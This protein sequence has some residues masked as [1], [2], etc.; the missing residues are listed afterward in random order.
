M[1]T[2]PPALIS[3][4]IP[5]FVGAYFKDDYSLPRWEIFVYT[6]C[7]GMNTMLFVMMTLLFL[8]VTEI[9]IKRRKKSVLHLLSMLEP[10]LRVREPD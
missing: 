9:D 1:W 4:I 6:F 8:Q 10:D 7:V 3:A 5:V 2:L